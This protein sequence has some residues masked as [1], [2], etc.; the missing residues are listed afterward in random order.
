MADFRDASL[1]AEEMA[2]TGDPTSIIKSA[3][4][5]RKAKGEPAVSIQER[6]RRGCGKDWPISGR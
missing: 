1:H 4:I 2:D 5:M 3:K 6:I